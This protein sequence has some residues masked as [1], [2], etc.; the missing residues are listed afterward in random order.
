M[1]G[2]LDRL[3][4][5][6]RHLILA[7]V[8]AILLTMVEVYNTNPDAFLA[9]VP[10]AFSAIVAA[11]I[12]VLIAYITPFTTQYGV[13]SRTAA[14]TVVED[15]HREAIASNPEERAGTAYVGELVAE[16]TFPDND[17]PA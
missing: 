9:S 6:L 11:L 3:P 16:P 7:V 17:T 2:W 5:A 15:D 8:A 1:T 13:G 12:T 10:P 14:E 4:P